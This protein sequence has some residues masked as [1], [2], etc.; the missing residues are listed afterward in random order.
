LHRLLCD[1]SREEEGCEEGLGSGVIAKERQ[2]GL[3]GFENGS[4]I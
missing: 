4:S 3:E 2:N 1:P